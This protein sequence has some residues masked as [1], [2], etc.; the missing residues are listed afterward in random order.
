MPAKKKYSKERALTKFLVGSRYEF[1]VEDPLKDFP[2]ITNTNYGHSNP[3]KAVMMYKNLTGLNKVFE[4]KRLKWKVT[5]NVEFRTEKEGY[6]RLTELVWFGLLHESEGQY[7]EAIE[8]IFARS[9]MDHYVICH[10]RAEVIGVN[11]IKDSD[12]SI[13]KRQAL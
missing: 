5:V 4:V 2:C 9:N 10:I 3:I 11:E 7:Q 13:T 1:D 12:F 6:N 8:D